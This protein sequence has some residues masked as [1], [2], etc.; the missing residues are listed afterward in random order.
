MIAEAFNDL[1]NRIKVE[2]DKVLS[3]KTTLAE[4]GA[5]KGPVI[6]INSRA[7]SRMIITTRN[8]KLDRI[9]I[10]KEDLARVGSEIYTLKQMDET[11]S[12]EL[13]SWHAFKE[14]SPSE[15]LYELSGLI[16]SYSRGL[17]LALEVP[18]SHLHEKELAEC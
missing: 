9:G 14:A 11:E 16:V 8:K 2:E 13:F 4:I 7:G 18:R 3:W 5:I 12:I 1:L 6:V 10:R 15:D 17:P